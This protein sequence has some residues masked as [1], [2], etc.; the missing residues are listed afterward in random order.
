MVAHLIFTRIDP[1]RAQLRV[2]AGGDVAGE[3]AEHD[4]VAHVERVEE[5]GDTGEPLRR[6]RRIAERAMELADVAIEDAIHPRIDRVAVVTVVR[7]QLADDRS[8]DGIGVG[9][10][11]EGCIGTVRE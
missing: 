4:V 11:A 3:E 10:V 8:D 2:G 9:E 1:D 7:H 6:M 5:L